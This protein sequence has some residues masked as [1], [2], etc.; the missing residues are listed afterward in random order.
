LSVFLIPGKYIGS[1][2]N[3]VVSDVNELQVLDSHGD[4]SFD[5]M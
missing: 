4:R 2:L 3:N 1:N 5:V